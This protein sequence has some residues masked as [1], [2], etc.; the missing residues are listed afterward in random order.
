MNVAYKL[1]Y[2]YLILTTIGKHKNSAQLMYDILDNPYE[3]KLVG[4]L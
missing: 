1:P 4:I 3:V 2:R